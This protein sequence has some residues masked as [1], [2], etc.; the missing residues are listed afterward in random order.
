MTF[1]E[2]IKR[3]TKNEKD[4]SEQKRVMLT[5]WLNSIRGLYDMLKSFLEDY[6]ETNEVK[7]EEEDISITEE[8]LGTYTAKKMVI[9]TQNI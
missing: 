9:V 2:F 4:L 6:V 7:I 3:E 1:D 5:E 8:F